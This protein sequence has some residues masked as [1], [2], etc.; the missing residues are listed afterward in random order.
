MSETI[1]LTV[2][3]KK[4]KVSRDFLSLSPE[5]QER[6][7]DE[8]AQSMGAKPSGFM[9]EVNR[10][11]ANTVGGLVDF[12]NPF[13]TPAVGQ[14]LGMPGLTT[15]SAVT[16][17]ENVMERGGVRVAPD[18][19]PQTIEAGLAR[20]IGNAAGAIIPA[21]GAA[22]LLSSAGGIVGN[23]ADDAYRA[24]A[25]RM[26][27]A[28]ETAAGAISG[29]AGGGVREAGGP[30]WLA[31]SAEVAAP[32]SVPAA[33]MAA[34]GAGR[35]LASTPITGTAIR[36]ARG[37]ARGIAPMTETGAREQAANRLRELVGGEERAADLARGIDP[38]DPLNR[39]GAQQTGDP[40]LIGL[41]RAAMEEDPLARVRLE[42]RAAGTR[43]AASGEIAGMGG[44]VAS[45]RQFFDR[46]LTNFKDALNRQVET[47]LQMA[48][49]SVEG[50][51]PRTSE[52]NASLRVFEA[53]KGALDENLVRER[54]LWEAVPRSATVSTANAKATA[55]E[56]LEALPKTQ[57]EDFP[58]YARRWFIDETGL[59]DAET[60]GDLYGAYSKLGEIERAAMAGPNRQ[61]NLARIARNIRQAI[62]R[63]LEA[64]PQDQPGYDEITSARAFS[65]A[66]AETF[67]QGAVGR[68]LKRTQTGD[69][70]MTPEAALR[71]TVGVSGPEGLVASRQIETAAPQATDDVAEFLRGRFADAI[72]SPNGEFNRTV[73]AKWIRDNRELLAR[74]PD[75]NKEFLRAFKS[76]ETALAFAARA[77]LRVKAVESGSAVARFNSGQDQAAVASILS[78]DNPAQAARSVTATA[79]KD[80]SGK[81][82]AGVKGA[83]TDLLIG[84]ASTADGLSGP[85]LAALLEDGNIKM[86]MRQVFSADELSR[87]QQI[88]RALSTMDAPGSDVGGVIDSPSNRLLEYVVR[89]TAARQGGQMGGGT[90][91]G[92]LQTA[93]IVQERARAILRGLT[94]DRA[95]QM[96]MDAIEDPALFRALLVEPK[97]VNISAP[98]RS[99]LAPYLTGGI[100]NAEQEERGQLPPV[101]L[102]VV[103][104]DV[105]RSFGLNP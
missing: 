64:L 79:R 47:T 59:G 78:A 38:N 30:E 97:S 24:L 70:T 93:N 98:V 85:K 104:D 88:A 63:D 19:V 101:N 72:L 39:T 56:L 68:I 91:G 29:A 92:S 77:E 103:N 54:Q 80:P 49:E 35:V 7:V 53:I 57:S 86:A 69:E 100:A 84:K 20:G 89:I 46:R 9:G 95:R 61:E 10:G 94:N 5:D 60:V 90:M 71:R 16:G 13:D 42:E 52:S 43:T 2:E 66:L 31:Q 23:I 75:L 87:M 34:R 51:G 62:L 28:A 99:K 96:L 48:R 74:Y 21:T 44:D 45:A 17:I 11:I 76:Q 15:G 14:A 25:S 40:N 22:R 67:D 6:T 37:V 18:G 36:A 73:A 102:P 32:L 12:V 81:A 1:T 50:V 105:R 27:V 55:R 65:R 33:V 83:F 58:A 82:L 8:I 3:G 4:V 41:E 26:G